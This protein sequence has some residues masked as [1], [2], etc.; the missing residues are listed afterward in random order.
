MDLPGIPLFSMLKE[1]MAWLDQRQTVLSQ[2]VAN[3]DTP[4]YTAR[5]LKPV[6]FAQALKSVTAPNQFSGALMTDN[7]RHIAVT[8]TNQMGFADIDT[9]DVASNPS[10][11]SV[12]LEQEMIKVADTQAQF[13]AASNLYAKAISMMKTAIGKPGM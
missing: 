3:A 7:P 9:P 10:G 4:G 6:D 11:N 13:Q 1:R 12:S 2:N 8:P 5:D